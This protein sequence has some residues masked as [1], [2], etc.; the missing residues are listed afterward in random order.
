MAVDP[1]YI[2]EV[3][4][5]EVNY[6]D[7]LSEF[8]IEASYQNDNTNGLDMDGYMIT[9]LREMYDGDECT[10]KA[11]ISDIYTV[12]FKNKD[13]GDT[14]VNHKIDLVL[15]DDSYE[16]EK[17]A[18]VFPINLNSDNIDFEKNIVKNVNNAS[19]LYA[20]AMGLMELKAPKISKAFNHLDVV[21]V[22]KLQKQAE[23]Y[24]T[25]T[26]Q[27]IEKSFKN[28]KEETYY[29]SFKIIEGEQ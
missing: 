9:Q 19:G 23:Q 16:D 27:V 3:T 14:I 26:V 20:L 8:G 1:K 2:E 15:F 28:S 10:G 7:V 18:Y 11:V 12:E 13:T 17:E 6:D 25:L 5:E 22:K 29:N 21:G 24:K 4:D